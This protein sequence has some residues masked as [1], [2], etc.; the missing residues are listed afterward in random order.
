MSN[1][2]TDFIVTFVKGDYV[3]TRKITA[4]WYIIDEDGILHF[5]FKKNVS[6]DAEIASYAHGVWQTVELAGI[7]NVVASSV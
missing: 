1:G 2:S 3:I 6:Q 4:G 7:G 5:Y